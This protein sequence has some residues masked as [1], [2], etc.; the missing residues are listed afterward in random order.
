[1]CTPQTPDSIRT[2]RQEKAPPQKA[3]YDQPKK[4]S[5]DGGGDWTEERQGGR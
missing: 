2:S 4:L 3:E 1:M 5:N